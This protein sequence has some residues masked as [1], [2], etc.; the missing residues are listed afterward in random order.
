MDFSRRVIINDFSKRSKRTI[1]AEK[2]DILY[3][4]LEIIEQNIKNAIIKGENRVCIDCSISPNAR[5]MLEQIGYKVK[6]GSQYNQSYVNIE[7]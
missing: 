5:A 3:K 2:Q 4:E 7:W 6:C 1:R